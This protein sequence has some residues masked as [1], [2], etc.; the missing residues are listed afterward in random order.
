MKAKGVIYI[1]FMTNQHMTCIAYGKNTSRQVL[2][3]TLKLKKL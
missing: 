2:I 1:M 3:K